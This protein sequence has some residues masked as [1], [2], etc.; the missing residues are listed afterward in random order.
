MIHCQR[1]VSAPAPAS[2]AD[3]FMADKSRLARFGRLLA[4]N[5][6][7]MSPWVPTT[8]LKQLFQ[9]LAKIQKCFQ[10]SLKYIASAAGAVDNSQY[11][12]TCEWFNHFGEWIDITIC[13]WIA[14]GICYW[15][16][17]I[18]KPKGTNALHVYSIHEGDAWVLLLKGSGA[19]L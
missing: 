6:W 11:I 15:E 18:H 14:I 17:V 5:D 12:L 10:T 7:I 3:A 2:I 4:Q 9:F 13:Y 8:L 16:F 1:V 19:P